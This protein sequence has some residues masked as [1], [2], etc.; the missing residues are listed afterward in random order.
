[1]KKWLI[2]ILYPLLLWY[3]STYSGQSYKDELYFLANSS[4]PMCAIFVWCAKMKKLEIVSPYPM[5]TILYIL[6]F[7]VAPMTFI[8]TND[9]DCHGDDVMEGC[10]YGTVLALVSFLLLSIGY[11]RKKNVPEESFKSVYLKKKVKAFSLAIIFWIIGAAACIMYINQTGVPLLFLLLNSGSET[12]PADIGGGSNMRF[13]A[14]FAYFM[15]YPV[16]LVFCFAKK[17]LIILPLVLFTFLLFYVRGTRIFIVIQVLSLILLYVRI[18]NKRIETKHVIIGIVCMICIFSFMGSNR[19]SVR[20]GD[21]IEYKLDATD[22][23]GMLSTNFDIY[24][25]YY[26]LVAN[27]P[28]KFGFTFGKGMFLES[29]ESLIPRILWPGKST[30]TYMQKCLSKTTGEGPISAAM[31]W[32]NIAEYYMEFGVIGVIIFSYL[33]GY[34][35]SW[36]L[37][38]YRSRE[39]EKIILYALLYPTFFELIIRGYTPINFTMYICLLLPYYCEKELHLLRNK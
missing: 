10:R 14:S 4:L 22:V 20:S 8:I 21:N 23:F 2:F 19:N 18:A 31:S 39:I 9:T 13:L 15:V 25:P 38:L 27:C 6:I 34:V 35:M 28:E 5:A 36:S 11:V 29:V 33:L 24:K 26:G 7:I 30:T 32:P 17:K 12:L 1:M 37:N 16:T 3:A